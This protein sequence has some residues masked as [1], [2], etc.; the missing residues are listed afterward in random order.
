MKRNFIPFNLGLAL[1]IAL[2]SCGT[3]KPITTTDLAKLSLKT[4]PVAENDLMRWS[5]VDLLKDTVPGMSVDKAY[6]EI[7][8][9]K[10]GQK[11]IVGIVDSGVDIN[12]EDLKAAIWTNPKEIAENGIDDDNNGYIDDIHGWNFLGNAVNEQ[13]EMTRIVKKG[14]GTPDYEKAKEKLDEEIK[15]ITKEKQQLDFILNA[16][17]AIKTHLNKETF[18]L[19]DVKGIVSNETSVKQ[20]KAMF[21]QFL[22]TTT[23]DKFD[24]EI[25]EYKD[26]VYGNLNYK[27]NVA[28][29]GR[30]VVG[31]NPNDLNDTKYGNNNVFGPDPKAAKH[32]T[33][34]AGIVAQ[35]RGNNIG[36]DGVSNTAEIMVIRAVPNGDEYDKDIALGIR[37]AVDNGAKVI[38]GSFGKYFSQN[39]EWVMDAIKYAASKDVLVVVAAG[40]E[41]YDL[42]VTNKY[43]NDTYDGSPEYTN[44]VLIVGALS[45]SYDTKMVADFSNYGKNNVD[46]YAPGDQIYATTPLNTYEYLQGTSMASPNVAGVAALVRS[47]YPNLTA[48]QVKQ[49]I[50]ES[51][52]AI[53]NTVLLGEDKH[54]TNFAEASKSG[55]IINAYNA[56]LLAKKTV[57]K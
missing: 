24:A 43:P 46:I 54:K 57:K 11:V 49:I 6:N 10:K 42:D 47:Y 9:N 2:T 27:F 28:Y 19:E 50:M 45:P 29:D 25:E 18:T 3:Q 8:K 21:T 32:G 52:I 5:H 34:V 38:N 31:D 26:Y 35:V 40:N 53:K 41:S 22:S 4:T 20:A 55:R 37:Y 39:K 30:S 1:T 13:L 44:N 12:H 7:L 16:E 15:G 56:L 14:P 36:G 33:H 48:V 51:G 17:K 23:K